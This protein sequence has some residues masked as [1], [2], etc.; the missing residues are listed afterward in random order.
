MDEFITVRQLFDLIGTRNPGQ[1]LP[2]L[3]DSGAVQVRPYTYVWGP[4]AHVEAYLG[5]EYKILD[6]EKFDTVLKTAR[7]ID[8]ERR[9]SDEQQAA[10]MELIE[11]P[12]VERMFKEKLGN[13]S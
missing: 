1:H 9:L 12:D 6:Q 13:K 5:P 8:A 4:T 10:F 3:V 11:H 2:I 7:A